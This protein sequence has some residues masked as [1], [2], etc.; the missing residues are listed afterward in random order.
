M[1]II[2][3]AL[4]AGLHVA[5][6]DPCA[7]DH[8]GHDPYRSVGDVTVALQ[9]Y[10]LS[11]EDRAVIKAKMQAHAYDD[12]VFVQRD[13]I[14]SE[15]GHDV[16]DGLRDMHSGHSICHGP[17]STKTW[18]VT[19]LQS[20]LVYCGVGNTCV[21]VPLICNNVSLID[22]RPS[23]GGGGSDVVGPGELQFEPPS[24]GIT[25]LPVDVPAPAAAF[26]SVVEGGET[27]GYGYIP[28]YGG[29]GSYIGGGGGITIPPRPPYPPASAPSSPSCGCVPPPPPVC[30]PIL[31]PPPVTAVPEPGTWALLILGLVVMVLGGLMRTRPE[32]S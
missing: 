1:L 22:R 31:P 29:G 11:P 7:W 15:H 5:P 16:Y 32:R 17:V 26:A 2:A 13:G 19:E 4:A 30:P 3:L 14:T 27:T 9:D 25:P 8:P 20:A 21:I 24:A 18:A 28:P 10:S 6:P 23:D 12:F